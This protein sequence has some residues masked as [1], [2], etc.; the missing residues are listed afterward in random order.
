MAKG[1]VKSYYKAVFCGRQYREAM[2]EDPS[3]PREVT[4]DVNDKDE[5]IYMFGVYLT[6]PGVKLYLVYSDGTK[7]RIK[8]HR[9]LFKDRE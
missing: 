1:K 6:N 2:K 9:C 5:A 8:T 7:R 3:L 4:I